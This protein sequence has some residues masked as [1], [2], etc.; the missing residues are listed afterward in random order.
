MGTP[1]KKNWCCQHHHVGCAPTAPPVTRPPPPPQVVPPPVF[2]PPPPVV[3]ARPADPYNCADG[4]ANW[5]I[6]WS[7]GKKGWCCQVHGKGCPGAVAA[8]PYDCNAGFANWVIGWSVG[9]KAYCCQH[10]G[11]GCPTAAGGCE[12]AAAYDCNAGFANWVVV[13]SWPKRHGAASMAAKAA[14][15]QQLVVLRGV[16]HAYQESDFVSWRLMWRHACVAAIQ[17]GR[18]VSRLAL[19]LRHHLP[20]LGG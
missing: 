10:G 19:M 14:Q 5:V 13:W 8:E 1:Y 11:K 9:K 16:R 6:G 15:E 2:V 12:T 4:F 7:V 17:G 20:A 3:I 18:C